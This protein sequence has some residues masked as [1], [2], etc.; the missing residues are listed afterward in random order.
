MAYKV[1]YV[2]WVDS[3]SLGG[4]WPRD[5]AMNDITTVVCESVGFLV[6]ADEHAVV[7]VGSVNDSQVADFMSIPTVVVQELVVL[8]DGELVTLGD[9]TE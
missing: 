6:R 8:V 1:V 4:W 7:V 5:E 2:R 9:A 3:A